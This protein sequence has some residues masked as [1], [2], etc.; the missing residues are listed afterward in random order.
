MINKIILDEYI[1]IYIICALNYCV[2]NMEEYLFSIKAN[3]YSER[4]S[5]A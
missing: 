3:A 1:Y 2:G 5:H 4:I